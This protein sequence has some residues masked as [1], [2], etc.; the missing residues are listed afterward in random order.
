MLYF[1]VENMKYSILVTLI[2]AFFGTVAYAIEPNTLLN[3]KVAD[4]WQPVKNYEKLVSA[5]AFDYTENGNWF[6]EKSKQFGYDKC[7][8]NIKNTTFKESID[9]ERCYGWVLVEAKHGNKD[10]L[11]DILLYWAENNH[12]FH[13]SWLGTLPLQFEPCIFFAEERTDEV[14][15]RLGIDTV[16]D[17]LNPAKGKNHMH[18]DSLERVVDCACGVPAEVGIKRAGDTG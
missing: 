15:S 16:T 18:D 17:P 3:I 7:I 14:D 13:F 10:I 6:R 12:S 4:N 5:E 9:F 2:S 8:T 11:A 1:I